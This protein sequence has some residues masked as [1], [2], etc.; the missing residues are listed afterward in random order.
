MA[1]PEELQRPGKVIEET[2]AVEVAHGAAFA[3]LE[4]QAPGMASTLRRVI[5]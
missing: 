2:H 4:I 5:R 3:F 1:A